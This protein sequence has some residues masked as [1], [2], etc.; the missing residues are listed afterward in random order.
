MR[1]V[2]VTLDEPGKVTTLFASRPF[3]SSSVANLPVREER[4]G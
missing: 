1:T 2:T 4:R 3:G